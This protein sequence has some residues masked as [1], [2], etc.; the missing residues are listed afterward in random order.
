M[1]PSSRVRGYALLAPV[2]SLAVLLPSWP[3]Q[4][5]AAVRTGISATAAP[6]VPKL[7]PGDLDATPGRPDPTSAS[8]TARTSGER[9]EDLSERTEKTRVYANPDGTWISEAAPEPTQVRDAKGAWHL[10]DTTLVVKERRPSG[11]GSTSGA[12]RITGSK[13]RTFK[14]SDFHVVARGTDGTVWAAEKRAPHNG[15][16]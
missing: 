2:L 7:A 8:V 3:V 4:A 9:V 13:H 15:E 11:S 12:Q 1:S 16:I 5:D 6:A 14:R 10:V